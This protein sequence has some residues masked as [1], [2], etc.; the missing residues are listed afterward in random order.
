MTEAT[1]QMPNYE[2]QFK[3]RFS[4]EDE[5]YQEYVRRPDDPP[6]IVD[7]WRGSGSGNARGRGNRFQDH[8][9]NRG[10]DWQRNTERGRG[11]EYPEYQ[12][13]RDRKRHWE[14]S[15]GYQSGPQ[16]YNQGYNAYN[17]RFRHDNYHY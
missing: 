12:Q 2:E 1:D 9:G 13:R 10:C 15:S 16:G 6:P 3:H 7:N 17:K 14:Q 4:S 8:H 5:A 11:G